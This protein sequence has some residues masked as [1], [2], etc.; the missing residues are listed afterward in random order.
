VFGP[1]PAVFNNNTDTLADDG[2]E[3]FR[4]R[5]FTYTERLLNS[6]QTRGEHQFFKSTPLGVKWVLSTSRTT[7]DTPDRRFFSH[8]YTPDPGSNYVDTTFRIS[9]TLT[10]LPSRLF[11]KVEEEN[12]EFGTDFTL[13]MDKT[14]VFKFGFNR[15]NKDRIVTERKFQYPNTVPNVTGLW[16]G[17]IDFY[18][19]SDGYRRIINGTDTT[20]QFSGIIRTPNGDSSYT[21]IIEVDLEGRNNYVAEQ[22][23]TAGYAMFEFGLFSGLKLVTGIRAEQT[24]M[25]TENGFLPKVF[26]GIGSGYES[27]EINSMSLLPSHTL[28][29]S[30]TSDMNLRGSMTKTLAR[31]TLREFAPFSSEEIAGGDRIFNGNTAL[32]ETSITNYDVRW[33]WFTRPGEV[34][35]V[36]GFY[37]KFVDPIEYFLDNGNGNITPVNADDATLLGIEFELRTKLDI[38]LPLL[39]NFEVNGNVALVDAEIEVP[40]REP[41]KM[42]GQSPYV[43]N[44]GLSYGNYGL[45][46]DLTANVNRFGERVTY[47]TA[48]GTPN[49]LE[50]PR[51]TLDIVASQRVFAGFTIKASAKNV[52]GE[53]Y[54][55][56]QR[57]EGID[58]TYQS[59]KREPSYSLGLNWKI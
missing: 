33:E 53:D 18:T 57:F 13:N 20:Y 10:S 25:F 8:T 58:Y 50:I 37:K 2:L 12:F 3:R 9:T 35:A 44:V 5:A 46:F 30:V 6:F 22:K 4:G 47:V 55:S 36:S 40:G 31:P 51:T 49:V 1:A 42:Y 24:E 23:I 17:N 27:G 29:W 39:A 11:T 28:I 52:L 26:K 34:V 54:R 48:P 38:L 7:Q 15:V 43:Y 41:R 56:V 14:N 16:N 45:G 21:H 59:Y 19:N 32:N